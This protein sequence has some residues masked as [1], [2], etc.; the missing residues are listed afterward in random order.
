MAK[1]MAQNS[2]SKLINKMIKT[3]LIILIILILLIALIFGMYL[4][5]N[6]G[7]VKK[8]FSGMI[9]S[10]TGEKVDIIYA[11]ILGISEDIETELTDTIIVAAYNPY[12]Q[13]AYMLS[14]PRDTYI[15]KNNSVGKY[16]KIN[17]IYSKYGI[18]KT[19]EYAEELTNLEIDYYAIVR[20]ST[21]IDIVDIIGGVEFNVPFDMDYD[22]ETQDLHIDLKKGIQIINGKKAEQLLR[23]RHN[24]DGTTYSYEYGDNDYGRMKTQREFINETVKQ[25]IQLKNIL[26]VK[27]I[28]NSVFEN[29]ETNIGIEKVLAYV[30]YAI[31][32]D[33]NNLLMEQLPG[34]SIQKNG[35][36]IFEKNV[37]K[38][39]KIISK[40]EENLKNIEK[41]EEK[42]E[43][44]NENEIER[45]QFKK[46]SK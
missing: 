37:S 26:K 15:G 7:N 33:I 39:K 3:I 38:T 44:K 6:K 18:E 40:L 29:I 41:K 2:N 13:Q 31:E 19:I 4:I 16:D 22:D 11:L 36:W 14:I 30:P 20:T 1:R 45:I 24:N 35:I 43:I 25:T 12:T 32:F 27:K 5:K 42:N 34:E 10:V 17:A 21:L 23:F 9:T 46:N 8:T 28:T